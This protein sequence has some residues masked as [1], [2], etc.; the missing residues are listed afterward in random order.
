MCECAAAFVT[1][2]SRTTSASPDHLLAN[3]PFWFSLIVLLIIS[4]FLKSL[5]FALYDLVSIAAHK[6]PQT[7]SVFCHVNGFFFAM[8]IEAADAA[9]FLIALH[10]TVYIFWPNRAG[11]DSGIYPYR[12]GAYAFF[13]LWPVLMASLAFVTGTSAYANTG[14]Y[15]YLSMKPWWYRTALSWIPRY[16]NLLLILLMYGSSYLYIRVMMN[17]YSRR[18]SKI[19]V[20]HP[21]RIA[22]S[23]PPLMAHDL[24]S[25]P[26]AGS[27]PSSSSPPPLTESPKDTAPLLPTGHLKARDILQGG[28][29]MRHSGPRLRRYWSWVGFELAASSAHTPDPSSAS[30][31]PFGGMASAG[32]TTIESV[33]ETAETAPAPEPVEIPKLAFL[34]PSS[35]TKSSTGRGCS[36]PAFLRRLS[37]HHAV[38]EDYFTSSANAGLGRAHTTGSQVHIKKV[39]QEGP[40]RILD[41]DSGK[42][43]PPVALD[44]ATF[45]SGGILQSRERLRRQLRYLFVYPAVY[46]CVWIFPFVN[47]LG[48]FSPSSSLQEHENPPYWLALCSLVSLSIQGLADSL[49]FCAR[50]K[51]WRHLRRGGFWQS[52]GLDFFNGWAFT[53]RKDS[54]RTREEMFNDSQRARSRREEELEL[55]NKVRDSSG[56]RGRPQP[57][58][59]SRNWWDADFEGVPGQ[60]RRATVGEE[61]EA[62]S[63]GERRVSLAEGLSKV[64]RRVLLDA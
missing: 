6:Q 61:G 57:T 9:V 11:G 3:A 16:V 53:L 31:S 22:P 5:W 55:E 27:M 42:S 19:P 64:V 4:D 13:A 46:A 38:V 8:G 23:T 44:Q 14:Q 52:L 30:V 2:K 45:E 40:V 47:D 37:A 51:P 35:S 54:G 29:D 62:G 43:S 12:R 17:R 28:L 58:A 39:L 32:A 48:I 26:P 15:C 7:L 49:V 21:D 33:E 60:Q 63:A 36:S 41:T 34:K 10:S 1:S 18:N 24:I 56:G 50:E 25:L 59:G 20:G